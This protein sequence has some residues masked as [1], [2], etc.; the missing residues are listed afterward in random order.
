[1]KK[2]IRKFLS[3]KIFIHILVFFGLA[4]LLGF[5]MT[6][7]KYLLL[8]IYLSFGGAICGSFI[9]VIDKIR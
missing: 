6:D 4:A 9:K 8:C 7:N 5:I 1:M 3:N 2:K